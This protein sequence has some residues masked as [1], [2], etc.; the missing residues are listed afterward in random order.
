MT[1][2]V[3]DASV[4]VKW[5][6]PEQHDSIARRLLAQD[7]ERVAPELVVTEVSHVFTKRHRRDEMTAE[8]ARVSIQTL[9]GLVLIV[10]TASLAL[11][12][13]NLAIAHQRSAYDALYAAL[14]LRE[15]CQLVTADRR[16]YEALR[17]PFPTTMLW[18]EDV[19]PA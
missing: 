17:A 14:A 10:E 3:V 1:R 11:E 15:R 18:I 2:L 7:Y 13:L 5:F 19:P 6:L 8:T 9:A 12:A 16:L 4:A